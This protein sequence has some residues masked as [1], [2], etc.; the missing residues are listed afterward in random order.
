LQTKLIHIYSYILIKIETY[1]QKL[2]SIWEIP[3]VVIDVETSGSN[4]EN[5]RITEIACVTTLGGEVA[6]TYSSLVNPHQAIPYFISKMTGISNEMAFLA[7]EPEQVIPI[8]NEKLSQPD[9]VFVAHNAR[10][11]WYFVAETFSRAGISIPKIPRLCTL[12]LSRRLLTKKERKNVGALADY[13]NIPIENRHRALG[14]ALATAHIL[15]ELLEFAEQEYGIENIEQLLQFQNKQIRNLKV[16]TSAY[17]RLSERLLNLPDNPGV[18]HFI[19]KYRNILYI[20]K[21]KSLSSR[22]KSY[23][24][25]EIPA[26]KKIAEMIK[27]AYDLTWET[28]GSELSALI[29]ESRKIKTIKPPYNTANKVYKRY[30]L[31]KISVSEEY[32]SVKPAF[33]VIDDG[34]IY[35]GPFHSIETMT[36]I[37][38]V[39][40]KKF[41]LKKCNENFNLSI[42]G[43]PCFYYQ[44]DRCPAPCVGNITHND[45]NDEVNKVSN[46]LSG[47]TDGIINQMEQQMQNMSELLEYEKAQKL[48]ESIKELKTLFENK[49]NG[50]NAIHNNNYIF[51][52]SRLD[53]QNIVDMY[54]VK[55]GKLLYQQL[56]EPNSP[57]LSY[58]QIIFE[59]FA[60]GTEDNI[61]YDD[62]DIDEVRII[63]AYATRRRK[64]GQFIYINNQ[65]PEELFDTIQSSLKKIFAPDNSQIGNPVSDI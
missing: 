19:D 4:P 34:A 22:V 17:N 9:A 30:P 40:D 1:S 36:Q 43:R 24:N 47:Y 35:F 6:D 25:R 7:P 46:F 54:I 29:L 53:K 13:F 31:I 64:L 39:I 2:K 16:P 42:G 5:N 55:S 62:E 65:T 28:T 26:S 63:N 8:V 44:I 10:F 27:Q 15:N 57:S 37:L 20:G 41:K 23:F 50:N 51:L 33:N 38:N 59:N 56:I 21:A 3:F 49:Y 61:I 52:L 14:D 45:Y 58:E 48:K 60:N 18:Y 32:P 12:K 11:D